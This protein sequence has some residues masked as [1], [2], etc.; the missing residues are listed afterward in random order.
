M[1]F[2]FDSTPASSVSNS[3]LSVQEADDYFGGRFGADKW[4]TFSNT[5]KQQ[6]LVTSTKQLETAVYGGRRSKQI[7]SLQWPRVGLIDGD[8]YTI[9]DTEIPK[10]LKEATCEMAFW[11]WTEEDR[12]LSDTEILQVDT[13][14]VGPIDI[15]VNKERIVFP[16]KV[17]EMI[18][19]IGPGVLVD[20][21]TS[22]TI[23]SVRLSR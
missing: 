19:S 14:K 4:S 17:E 16:P 7:Q 2:T 15:A 21:V 20:A 1:A 12:L 10:K 6:L 3:Y 23:S 5:Q 13:Y 8:G 22:N 11:I 18:K 9:V